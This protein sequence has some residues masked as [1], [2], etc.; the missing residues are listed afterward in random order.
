MRKVLIFIDHDII[1]RNF[2]K[3]KIFLKLQKNYKIKFIFPKH[4]RVSIKPTDLDIK[5]FEII[6]LDEKR[7]YN[8]KI[9]G[10]V[11]RL[12]RS[13]KFNAK[14][15]KWHFEFFRNIFGRYLIYY[16]LLKTLP[17]V[18]P[19]WSYFKKREIGKNNLLDNLI[20]K[21]RPDL[22]I[23]PTVLNGLFVDD[24]AEICKVKKIPTLYLMNSWD[25]P[26]SKNF[27]ATLPD[28]LLVWGEESKIE[29]Q[30]FIGMKKKNITISGPAYYFGQNDVDD[31]KIESFRKNFFRE[32]NTFFLC[33]AGSSKGLNEITHLKKIDKLITNSNE[34]IK[35]LYR[36]HPWKEF[37]KNEELFNNKDFKNIFLDPFSAKNYSNLF[38]KKSMNID[39]VSPNNISLILNSVDAVFSPL[40]TF[41]IDAAAAGKPAAS[42]NYD[43]GENSKHFE[44]FKKRVELNNFNKEIQSL[45]CYHFDE[46]WSTVLKLKK[47]S[48]D[49]KFKMNIKIK[50]K[51]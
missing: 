10:Y 13:R 42:Y 37:H 4:K 41:I 19:I 48:K 32:K 27:I 25:N 21:N 23:H 15:K 29:A 6:E 34:N 22:I 33:Y 39:D 43:D 50:S 47:L 9:F 11:N 36:P 35:V 16:Q 51:K 40:S 14:D 2:Y 3:L 45:Q 26:R 38:K 20:S 46:I 8:R 12:F 1:I 49:E 5:E 24:L 44:I 31:N 30:E 18:Y 17:I 28:H 7:V